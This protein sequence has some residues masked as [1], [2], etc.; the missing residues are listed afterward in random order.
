MIGHRQATM[1]MK[2]LSHA[3]KW[4]P[5]DA[6]FRVISL[7]AGVQSTTMALMAAH[8]EIT[9]MPDCAIFADTQDEAADTYAHLEW[10][11]GVLPFPVHRP[12]RGCLSDALFSGDD[13]ARIPAF[14][15]GK[16]L[17]QRQCTWNF[18]IRVIRRQV[19]KILGVSPNGYIPP[20]SVEQWIGISVDE[21]DRMKAASVRFTVNRWP[22]IELG[23][24]R[25][26]CA[27]W[28]WEKYR[29]VAP[30]SSC[31]YCPFQGDA[32][33]RRRKESALN[34]FAKACEVDRRLRS[35]ENIARFGGREL[36]LHRSCRP[37]SE[38]DFTAQKDLFSNECEGLCGV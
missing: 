5:A 29:R 35:P 38:I 4:S 14:V 7:G 8:G 13:E 15:K 22:L 21:A 24:N 33:W 26:A 28:L 25:R 16:G 2:T 30:K 17:A 9:P 20:G 37:L 27:L 6:R 19:R 23:M 31:V 32:Q 34:D 11:C 3:R 1:I 36:F 12:T 10:L 18:K